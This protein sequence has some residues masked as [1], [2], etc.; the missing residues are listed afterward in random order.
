MKEPIN[1]KDK[2]TLMHVINTCIK[3]NIGFQMYESGSFE[4]SD[5]HHGQNRFLFREESLMSYN[6]SI[7]ELRD[8]LDVYIKNNKLS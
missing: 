2:R 6:Q 1:K 5:F 3:Y 8:K 4:V 7:S